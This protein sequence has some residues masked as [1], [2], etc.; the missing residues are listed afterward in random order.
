MQIRRESGARVGVEYES[1]TS[2]RSAF[3]FHTCRLAAEHAILQ[4]HRLTGVPRIDSWAA[5]RP[6]GASRHIDAESETFCFMARVIKHLHPARGKVWDVAILGTACTVDR[7]NFYATQAGLGQNLQLFCQTLL[8]DGTSGPP[9]ASPRFSLPS[10]CRPDGRFG[11]LAVRV[12]REAQ[13]EKSDRDEE[14]TACH[15]KPLLMYSVDPEPLD[16]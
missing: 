9:P 6:S 3:H 16:S 5:E 10:Y 1:L 15:G 14:G 2:R 12:C 13:Q 8:I 11:M 4:R 7:C